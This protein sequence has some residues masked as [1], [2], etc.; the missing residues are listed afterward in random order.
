M[1]AKWILIALALTFVHV[2]GNASA[3]SDFPVPS[4]LDPRTT[5]RQLDSFLARLRTDEAKLREDIQ[6]WRERLRLN[7]RDGMGSDQLRSLT[8]D[9]DRLRQEAQRIQTARQAIQAE[10][11]RRRAQPAPT[12]G[13]TPAATPRP[14][15]APTPSATP[16]PTPRPTPAPTPRSTPVPAPTPRPTPAPTPPI[17]P[18]RTMPAS[19]SNPTVIGGSAP[20]SRSSVNPL[21]SILIPRGPS[22]ANAR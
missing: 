12:S 22:N 18:P 13:A 16:V 14:T 15:P 19:P 11:A 3:Q 5:D 17:T 2:S 20:S 1:N 9:R 21:S 10:Q 8:E 6:S 4:T 7:Q